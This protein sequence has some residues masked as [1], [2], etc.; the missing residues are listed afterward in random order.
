MQGDL[1]RRQNGCRDLLR[2]KAAIRLSF[3]K[4]ARPDRVVV[5]YS[6]LS[7]RPL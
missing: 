5:I 7:P 1:Q 6:R 4:G 2:L 3:V